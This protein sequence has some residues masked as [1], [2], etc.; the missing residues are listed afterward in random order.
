MTLHRMSTQPR[1][2]R[3]VAAVEFAL[4][5]AGFFTVYFGIIEFG[6][7]LFMMNTVVEATRLGARTAVVCN[8]DSSAIA[9]KMTGLAGF[10]SPSNI[11]VSYEPAG[12]DINSCLYATVRVTGLTIQT[13]VP[14]VPLDFNM[15]AFSTTLPR[16]S[17]SSTN[18]PICA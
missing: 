2:Q 1:K 12:C 4:I 11:Q 9:N 13:L 6:R 10:L 16:E 7:V 8:K 5:A 15:P 3:G 18:N 14:L 17:M